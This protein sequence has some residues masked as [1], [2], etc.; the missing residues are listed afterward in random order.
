MG[1]DAQVQIEVAFR[2]RGQVRLLV[3]PREGKIISS[4]YFGCQS[5]SLQPCLVRTDGVSF[6]ALVNGPTLGCVVLYCSAVPWGRSMVPLSAPSR[7]PLSPHLWGA[8]YKIR[9]S[10]C[11]PF[12]Y[13]SSSQLFAAPP[14]SFL[15]RADAPQRLQHARPNIKFSPLCARRP[16]LSE[17][18][19]QDSDRLF[20]M[21]STPASPGQSQAEA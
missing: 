20:D 18:P 3:L 8:S 14:S 10:R 9:K 15:A 5:G 16:P 11:S 13:P 1:E 19:A 7:P 6:D 2:T 12:H 17:S 21:G 4:E